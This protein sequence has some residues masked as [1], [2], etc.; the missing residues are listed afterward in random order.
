MFQLADDG[1]RGA[2]IPVL[3]EPR[4]HERIGCGRLL[5]KGARVLS[6]STPMDGHRFDEFTRRAVA[7]RR[8]VLGGV[9][10]ALAAVALHPGDADIAAA[11]KE[12]CKKR[13]KNG[14]CTKKYGKCIR[15][16]QQTPTRCGTGGAICSSNCG[17]SS[18]AGTCAGCCTDDGQCQGEAEQS[19]ASCGTGGESCHACAAGELCEA[20]G[21]CCGNAGAPCG[22]GNSPCCTG[23]G[24][25]CESGTCC[26]KNGGLGCSQNTDCC[27]DDDVCEA[28]L[29]WRKLG[30]ACDPPGNI[31]CLPSLHCA[32]GICQ[33]CPELGHVMC[34]GS[35]CDQ[36]NCC[37]V[38][39]V[40]CSS[41]ECCG[42]LEDQFCCEFDGCCA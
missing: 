26:V 25:Q 9:T 38:L 31:H 19:G 4:S 12:P 39:G 11:K 28:G 36:R 16:A 14:C 1:D 13:C 22:S 10:A 37:E 35:C 17:G 27:D 20:P 3:A 21:V 29:C 23:T 18:C 2:A 5:L 33:E 30:A 7:S 42:G 41:G 8:F 24:L 32:D 34:G 15:P 40:C 6:R